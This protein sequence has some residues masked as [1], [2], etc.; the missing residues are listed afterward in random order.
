VVAAQRGAGE[1]RREERVV[2]V[3]GGVQG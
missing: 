2:M 1:A 3:V